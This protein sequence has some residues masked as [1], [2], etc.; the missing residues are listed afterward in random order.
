MLAYVFWHWPHPDIEQSIYEE[1]LINFHQTLHIQKPDGFRFSMVLRAE[2][3]PWVGG[4]RESY[5]DWYLIENSAGLDPLDQA[6][7]SGF[8]RE[9]HN[10]IAQWAA[11]GTGGL[12]RLRADEPG[13][14]NVQIAFWFAK[15]SGITYT[16]LYEQ[17]EPYGKQTPG[18][19][20]QRQMT[21]GPAPEFCWHM[22]QGAGLPP[23]PNALQ[24]PVTTIW[25]G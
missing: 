14:T 1:R 25:Q 11:G 22:P 3:Q 16:T 4:D 17:L 15:P 8:R 13:I 2:G 20:W 18:S 19:L 9:P 23:V 12:Y 6:A 5:E 21:L 24:I 7:V 10:Q